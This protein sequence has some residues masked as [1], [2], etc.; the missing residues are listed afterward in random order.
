MIVS[1]S[2][3]SKKSNSKSS[4]V[5]AQRR[6]DCSQCV[7]LERSP[8]GGGIRV[9]DG[10]GS[11]R[12]TSRAPSLPRPLP[13]GAAARER[14][15]G[16]RLARAR[17]AGRPRRGREDRPARG[18]VGR[19]RAPRGAG[20]GQARPSGVPRARTRAAATPRTSTSRT[21]TSRERTFRESLRAGRVTDAVA[22]EVAAQVLDGLAHAHERGI[23]HRDVKPANVL[24]ADA[25]G[26]GD[27][28][29]HPRLRP[30]ALR[31][32]RDAHGRRRR[33]GD[34]R[35]H[36]AR[37][38]ARRAGGPGGRRLV[39]RRAALRGARRAASVLAAVARAR[40]PRRSRRAAAAADR[41]AGPAGPAAR[42]GRP[43]ARRR[44]EEASVGG[45]ARADAAAARA[46]TTAARARAASTSIAQSAAAGTRGRRLC[47]R[48]R[49]AA[50]VLPGARRAAARRRGRRADARR[51]ALGLAFAL[52]VPIFPLGNVALGLAL[53]YA[54]LAAAAWLALVLT[55]G[56]ARR[57]RR[58]RLLGCRPPRRRERRAGAGRI[59]LAG[60]PGQPPSDSP[61]P[62]RSLAGRSAVARSGRFRVAALA[63][64]R[65]ALGRRGRR[66]S[67]AAEPWRPG[68]TLADA[69]NRPR[70]AMLR[71]IEHKIE[72]LFEGIFGR[73]FRT[74]VQP[75]ELARKLAK[76]MDEGKTVS[77]S[78]VYVP[79][80][81]SIFLAPDDRE[82]FS[83]YEESLVDELQQYLAEHA[84]R[85]GYA[86]LS[87]PR[88]VFNSDG[89]LAVGEFGIATRMVQQRGGPS[90]P[91]QR[92]ERDDDLPARAAADRGGDA[93]ELGVDAR[94]RHAERQ[95]RKPR[96]TKQRTMIGR[97]RDCDVQ[98]EDP[99]ASRRHAEVRQEGT[100]YWIVDLD[101][102]NGL[103]VN[104]M[105]TKRAKLRTA[106]RSR[107]ARPRSRSAATSPDARVRRGPDRA[108]RPEDL[109]PRAALPLHLADRAQRVARRAHAAG[110]LHHGPV[111]RR[112][113]P[114]S[115]GS[116][117]RSTGDARRASR[118][119]RSSRASR[120]ELNAKA[121]TVGRGAPNDIRLD[122]D[123]FASSITRASSR[124][125]TASGSRTSARRTARTS[126]ARASAAPQKLAPGDV[127]RIGETDL[128]YER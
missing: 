34:A 80:E 99:S 22:V 97:S 104:G 72:S 117:R 71:Q 32:R 21:R 76:E 33:P 98:I 107:S 55:R 88:V 66:A 3:S 118:A 124:A 109:L 54:A 20:D 44:S 108:A 111:S 49:R 42:G 59:V 92:A 62:R 37:A 4:S 50:S 58:S 6:G 89:D 28:R 86:L 9:S 105:R 125:A 69:G 38:A 79:N 25:R 46:A 73:A 27:L 75:V 39:G 126:T 45:E 112:P 82:Q 114:A 95:R 70:T 100:A 65:P 12:P 2:G 48:S 96:G 56:A 91:A 36:R 87:D 30:R 123:E 43:S 10:V 11:S 17:R 16:L 128:R 90:V 14:R 122:D 74:H 77:V 68:L 5:C 83:S 26:D 120:F 119:P 41:A 127:V 94:G 23:V 60:I 78:R 85:E 110:E 52:A 93:E 116:R 7:G 40:R 64:C 67:W 19:A 1:S 103:E 24:L 121:I 102:T 35:L 115:A 57:A 29:P 81:Y 31:G 47:R 13:R 8:T 84:R 18:Q 113:R 101:S 63:A 15:L 106:T 53:L 51:A 61:W